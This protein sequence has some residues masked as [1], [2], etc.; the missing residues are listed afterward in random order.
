MQRELPTVRDAFLS[1]LPSPKRRLATRNKYRAK[2]DRFLEEYG[3]ASINHVDQQLVADWFE[4]LEQVYS[5][6]TM[7]IFKSCFVAFFN[8][9]VQQQWLDVN[10]GAGLPYYDDKPKVIRTANESHLEQVLQC[11]E[12]LAQ[13]DNPKDRR[14][15]LIFAL[16][17]VSGAR[18]SNLTMLPHRE[19]VA[20]LGY[21]VYDPEVGNIFAVTTAGKEPL[22]IV[23]SDWHARLVEHYLEVR[24]NNTSHNRHFVDLRA[25]QGTY[26]APLGYGGIGKARKRICE[27]AGVPVI[28]Y[29]DMRKLKGT[30]VARKYGLELAAQ[31]LGHRS[32]TRV[33]RE[34]YYNPDRHATRLAILRTGIKLSPPRF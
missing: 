20:T 31:A 7:S 32:G 22:E 23:F 30:K 18:P 9:C 5:E 17:A 26:G 29:T 34:F 11:C 13:S 2:L 3:E 4:D 19:M 1:F 21:P 27:L 8:Y 24:P 6:G 25:K 28:T 10:P 14:D 16:A 12:A 15:G 33:I